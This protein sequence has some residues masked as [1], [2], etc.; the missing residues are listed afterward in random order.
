MKLIMTLLVKNEADIIES[1]IRFHAAQGVD[2]FLV[3]DNNSEDGTTDILK[4]LQKEFDLKLLHNT[5]MQYEQSKWMTGLAHQARKEMGA[6]IV[7]SN[8]ADEF[9]STNNGTTLKQELKLTDAT[10]TARRFNYMQSLTDIDNR[11]A[12]LHC[13]NK[14]INPIHYSKMDE[15]NNARALL[16]LQKIGPKV[17]VNPLGL[18]RIKGGN[19]KAKHLRFWA[20]RESSCIEVH[21]YPIR[22]YEQFEANILNRKKITQLHPER[23]MNTHYR[24]W[25]N[26]LDNGTL[27][28]EFENM[29]LSNEQLTVLEKV[30]VIDSSHIS[31]LSVWHQG[32]SRS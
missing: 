32:T 23:K 12:F 19:H 14:V 27:R 9:W 13:K 3:M 22:S 11:M 25:L 1:N 18:M 29:H 7:I 8:D 21:H 16:P 6:N 28:D 15:L 26:C 17:I 30:G 4:S 20:G 31:P 10:V 2:A 24:R 5:S